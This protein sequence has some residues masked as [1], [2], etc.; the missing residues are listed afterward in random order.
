VDKRKKPK[1]PVCAKP[2]VARWKPFCSDRC[3][4]VDLNRWLGG[5]YRIET[6]EEPDQDPSREE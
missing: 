1:C 2:M 4:R 6:D 5:V 3:R